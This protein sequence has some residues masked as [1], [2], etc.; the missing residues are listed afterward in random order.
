MWWRW[1]GAMGATG[2]VLGAFGAH[3]LR[4]IV[5]DPHL[6]EVWETAARYQQ[7]HAVALLGVA[8]H[9][10]QPKWAGRLFVAGIALFSGSLYLLALTDVRW[11]GAITPLGGLAFI[12]G[13]VA[14]AVARPVAPGAP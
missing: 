4:Q 3:A 10:A 6:I 5:L 7:I 2:V 11:L 14:L 1:A 9:P 8:A 12:A 13:W